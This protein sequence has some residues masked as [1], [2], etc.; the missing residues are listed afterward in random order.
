MK[1]ALLQKIIITLF[2]TTLFLKLPSAL[3]WS[4]YDFEDKTEIEIGEGNLVR[5]GLIIQFY[6]T[7]L[8]NY[9]S[10]KVLFLEESSG[11]SRLQVKDLDSKKER[12]FIMEN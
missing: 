10:A 4:G 2:L 5:E 12:V 9:R 1:I 8:D 7:K 11:G 3:A 6:D